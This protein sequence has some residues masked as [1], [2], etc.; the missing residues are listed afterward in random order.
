MPRAKKVDADELVAQK[1]ADA[2]ANPA[3]VPDYGTFGVTCIEMFGGL[4]E[5]CKLIVED[6]KASKAG[7]NYRARLI[8]FVLTTIKFRTE[9]ERPVEDYG[10]LSDED[11]QKEVMRQVGRK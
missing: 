8:E 7:S 3:S 9:R 1:L 6:L 11:L 10:L 5:F 2:I 4:N